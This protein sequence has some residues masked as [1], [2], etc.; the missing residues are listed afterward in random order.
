MLISY[1]LQPTKLLIQRTSFL[2]DHSENI[3]SSCNQEKLASILTEINE[4]WVNQSW[5]PDF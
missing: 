3:Y 1:G 2:E 4:K 5:K